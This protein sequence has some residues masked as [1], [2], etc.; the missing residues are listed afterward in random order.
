MDIS[1]FRDHIASIGEIANVL[2]AGNPPEHNISPNYGS[3]IFMCDLNQY[4]VAPLRL[5]SPEYCTLIKERYS[6]QGRWHSHLPS[7]SAPSIGRDAVLRDLW[8]PLGHAPFLK[9]PVCPNQEASLS[10]LLK[11]ISS[12]HVR[13][14]CNEPCWPLPR[15][16][17]PMP[18][19]S[20][21]A[22]STISTDTTIHNSRLPQYLLPLPDPCV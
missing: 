4:C 2:R 18:Q 19:L 1:M 20:T 14:C 17:L 16:P 22:T 6:P 12:L 7:H 8:T 11:G 13:Y 15:Y 10:P 21:L 9:G 3:I 5:Q